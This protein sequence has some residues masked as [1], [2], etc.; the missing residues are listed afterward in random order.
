[1]K[2]PHAHL[3]VVA[4]A[5]TRWLIGLLGLLLLVALFACR[6]APTPVLPT[7][8]SWLTLVAHSATATRTGVAARPTQPAQ[9]TPL[10]TKPNQPIL[11]GAL[12][13]STLPAPGRSPSGVAILGDRVYVSN[14][15]SDNV[16]VIVSE[17]VR[18]VVP[19]GRGPSAILA[20]PSLGHVFVLN[21]GDST[22]NVL[23]GTN[24]VATWAV[25]EQS[26]KLLLVGEQLWVGGQRGGRIAV[27][28]ARDGSAL[29]V[30]TLSTENATFHMVASRDGQ[31]VYALTYGR[32]HT[33]DVASQQEIG[34]ADLTGLGLLAIPPSGQGLYM[35]GY[36]LEKQQAYLALLEDKTLAE[37][38]RLPSVPDLAA[39][40][41][42]PASGRLYLLSSF[43]DELVIMDGQDDR[44]I[45]TLTVGHE[46]RSMALDAQRGL[47]Y[48]AN[49]KGD[50]VTV[51]D[52]VKLAV[53]ATVPV[54]LR[55]ESMDVD[56]ITGQLYVAASSANSILVLGEAGL[57]SKWPVGEYPSQVRVIPGT[58]L[59]AS[60]SLV[61]DKLTLLDQTG[62]VVETYATGH[63]PRG[64]SLDEMQ[65]RIFA[66]DT[67]IQWESHV[68]HTIA[69]STT[70]GSMEP[71]VQVVLDVRRNRFYA[72]AANGIPGSN[73]GYVVT[74]LDEGLAASQAPAPGQLSV[75]ELIYDEEMDRFY[76]T[77]LRMGTYSLQVSQA[78]DCQ[79]VH[80]VSF[81]RYP[82]A[83]ALNPA[84]R[85][86]W[87]VLQTVSV[88]TT[89]ADTLIFAYDTRTFGEV[90][91]FHVD[92]L[93]ESLAVDPRNNRIY[94]ANGDAGV[95]H[96]V[97]DVITSAP[98]GPLPYTTP[99]P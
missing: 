10:P 89:A 97:Q 87:V 61:E 59:V 6:R 65:R 48:V 50:N 96:L 53:I 38:R 76:A 45:A 81:N 91:S 93:V 66:G 26:S 13:V 75:V 99:T 9:A 22:L 70:A 82:A 85:H 39:L 64:I 16:S 55:M 72:V 1:M 32:L 31:R 20:A 30:V 34:R 54:A 67:V 47:L 57:V 4:K 18:S 95:I 68:T 8:T 52:T 15:A 2:I 7:P 78:E 12:P 46:P 28:S 37:A 58:G 24:V 40:L 84:T 77:S 71:P 69:I 14:R 21:E 23:E 62:R 80:L 60:L 29:G 90:A 5:T 11:I 51:V 88:R 36:D 44:R 27:L 83:M 63:R 73:Y 3:A 35:S 92:G 56:P 74:R 25:P 79:Q 17:A 98:A 94:L 42:D 41:S 33:I 43:T 19:V 86:L 49:T